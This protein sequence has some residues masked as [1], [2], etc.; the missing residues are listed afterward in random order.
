MPDPVKNKTISHEL[1][2]YMVP[3]VG[4]NTNVCEENRYRTILCIED[5]IMFGY[6]ND[7]FDM[8]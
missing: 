6:N 1:R 4:L 2:E 8:R 3:P 5:N 7:Y